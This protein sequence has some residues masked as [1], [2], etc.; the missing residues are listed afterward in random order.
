MQMQSC[1]LALRL[2]ARKALGLLTLLPHLLEHSNPRRQV[3]LLYLKV[4]AKRLF[5][6]P[7]RH[8]RH[9]LH[10]KLHCSLSSLNRRH[11]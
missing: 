11:W 2:V 8:L 7:P 6:R 4:K 5:R 1:S 3:Q 10:P 9:R